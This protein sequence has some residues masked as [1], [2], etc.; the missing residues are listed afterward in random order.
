MR[1]TPT[2]WYV[3]TPYAKY[4]Q[5]HHAAFVMASK[6]GAL[7]VRHKVPAFVPIA[8]SH[9]IAMYGSL[10]LENHDIW[11]PVDEPFIRIASG[12]VVV[13]AEGWNES[14]GLAHE[15]KAFAAAGKPET[16]LPWPFREGPLFAIA[17]SAAQSA[18]RRSDRR[19]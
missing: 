17:E 2:F 9:P 14:F 19:T 8:H 7:M 5:G 16:F 11:L 1:L 10:P 4:P 6:V 3:A 12:I 13:M 18:P 15:R